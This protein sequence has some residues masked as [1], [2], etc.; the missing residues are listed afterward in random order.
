MPEPFERGDVIASLRVI[1]SE[2]HGQYFARCYRCRRAVT[3]AGSSLR[4]KQ[5]GCQ[6]CYPNHTAPRLRVYYDNHRGWPEVQAA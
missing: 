5:C 2:K 4:R 1:R 3:V 6:R